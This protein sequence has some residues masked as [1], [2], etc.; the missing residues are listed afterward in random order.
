MRSLTKALLYFFAA[1]AALG[2]ALSVVSHV[3]ALFGGVGPLGNRVLLLHIGIFFVWLPAALA[4]QRLARNSAGSHRWK[5]AL[6]ACPSWMRYSL[7]ALFG[8]A[9][10][11]FVLCLA[12]LRSGAPMTSVGRGFSLH[13]MVCYEAAAAFLYSPAN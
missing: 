11:N 9:V 7:S 8:Y 6:R 3:A 1:L 4:A 5:A 13:G 10:L 2:L 12:K